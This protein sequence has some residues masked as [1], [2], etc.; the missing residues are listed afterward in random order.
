MQ[1]VPTSLR[2]ADVI[3]EAHAGRAVGGRMRHRC[4][5][6]VEAFDVAGDTVQDRHEYAAPLPDR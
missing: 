5:M 6:F 4:S 1:S 2:H 3:S